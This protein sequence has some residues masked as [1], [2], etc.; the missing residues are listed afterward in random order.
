MSVTIDEYVIFL[1]NYSSYIQNNHQTHL[2]YLYDLMNCSATKKYNLNNDVKEVSA[3][4]CPK[5][6]KLNEYEYKQNGIREKK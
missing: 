1:I 3:F 5:C 4:T 2:K 6:Y